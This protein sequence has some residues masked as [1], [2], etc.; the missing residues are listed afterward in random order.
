MK[1][2]GLLLLSAPL[3]ACLSVTR[4]AVLDSAA[5]GAFAG[6]SALLGGPL[7]AGAAVEKTLP[8]LVLGAGGGT[9]RACVQS[10]VARG[11]PCIAATRSGSIARGDESQPLEFDPNSALVTLAAADVTSPASLA[12]AI[13]PGLGGV[14]FA[15]S[16]SAKGGDAAAVDRDGVIAAA[17]CCIAA[18][19]P[20]YVVVSSGT[21]TRPDSAV[22]QLLN[23]VGKGIMEAKIAGEDGAR[24]L[25]R[26]EGVAAQGLG[27]TVVRP[28]GLTS[29]PSR[30]AAALELNQGDDKSGRLSRADVAELCIASLASPAAFDATFECYERETAKP[31]ER[32]GLSNL[33]KS[34][35]PTPFTSGRECTGAELSV[36]LG[37]LARDA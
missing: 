20:R 13:R 11:I 22:Y 17:R 19:V 25:Y 15:A 14:I 26:E 10:L 8:V 6:S 21:V 7:A 23:L 35:D 5:A 37:G 9:G 31:V 24:A 36:L 32:V 33:L 3:A 27:Y 2:V 28:G 4:R 16:A 34:R 30:G 18:R 12:A 29:G 1:L